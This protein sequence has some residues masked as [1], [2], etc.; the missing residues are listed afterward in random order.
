MDSVEPSTSSAAA[1][2]QPPAAEAAATGSEDGQ[3]TPSGLKD[4]SDP[5]SSSTEDKTEGDKEQVTEEAPK[6]GIGIRFRKKPKQP[7]QRHSKGWWL[8]FVEVSLNIN[9]GCIPLRCL[10]S[11]GLILCKPPQLLFFLNRP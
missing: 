8:R 3:E 2:P 4:T 5:S 1:T 9:S 10:T 11:T 6:K 7:K